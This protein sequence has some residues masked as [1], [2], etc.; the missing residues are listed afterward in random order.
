MIKDDSIFMFKENFENKWAQIAWLGSN[1][2]A[3]K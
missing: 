3:V 2:S 1:P